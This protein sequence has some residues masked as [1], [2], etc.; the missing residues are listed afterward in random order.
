MANIIV[1]LVILLIVALSISK[2][3]IEKRKGVKCVGCAQSASC[4]SKKKGNKS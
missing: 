4:A 3:V 1:G 2:I